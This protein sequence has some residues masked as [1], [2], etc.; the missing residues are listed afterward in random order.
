MNALGVLGL[1]LLLVLAGI[2]CCLG[3]ELLRQNGRLL[4]RLEDVERQLIQIGAASRAAASDAP[5]QPPLPIGAEAPDFELADLSGKK[6]RLS[7]YR[8]RRVLL[9]FFNP[10]CVFCEQM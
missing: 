3:F 5:T 8:G 1:V 2:G 4:L 7:E 9:V 10:R 6:S